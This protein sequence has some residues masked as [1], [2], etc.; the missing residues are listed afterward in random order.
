V[1]EP[2][3]EE[4][5]KK[6]EK[7]VESLEGGELALEDSLKKYEEGVRLAQTCAKKLDAAQRK[8]DVLMKEQGG[9]FST[10]PFD[11]SGLNPNE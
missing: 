11:E 10:K 7:I 3:F 4:A 1:A 5:L 2:K 8:V 6:L 9:T